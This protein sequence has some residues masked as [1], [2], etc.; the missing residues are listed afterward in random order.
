MIRTAIVGRRA[1]AGD[2]D[3]REIRRL[4][5][6]TGG[7]VVGEITQVRPEH[8]AT[9]FGPGKVA[10]IADRVDATG[11][12]AFVVDNPLT[13]TQTVNLEDAIDAA[14][15]DRH[16]VVLE[17]FAE[18]A[19]SGRAQLQVEL[20]RLRYELPRIRELDDPQ[21]MNIAQEKGHW[22]KDVRDR[23]DDLEGKLAEL[24]A[25]D[26]HRRG[27]RREAGFDLVAIAGYTN[28]GKTTLLRRLADDLSFE[29]DVHDDLE[30]TAAIEDRLFKT[31]E[32]TT[33]RATLGGR[34]VLLTD[35][36]GFLDDLP[37]WLV[38]S[39]RGT[40]AEAEAA[41]AVLLVAD[42]AQP[43]DELERKL[44]TARDAIP[45]D[46]PVVTALNKADLVAEDEI[47][48]R[49]TTAEALAPNPVVTSARTA[50]RMDELAARIVDALPSLETAELTLPLADEAM[51]V[52]SWL[53]DEAASVDVEYGPEAVSAEFEAKPPGVAK[54]RSRRG[55]R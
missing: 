34:D 42:L 21:P 44:A 28:A 37:H 49:L 20:A 2:P 9:Q 13:P 24:P 18:R 55:E 1:D 14:V 46:A 3:T 31:L 19:H 17:I 48:E 12:T 43:P 7:R 23:I 40:L 36:V 38:E 27:R 39:F 10:A 45:D 22:L 30:E 41:D 26:A 33:R 51:S 52:V 11:A 16:R 5:E 53:H 29:S 6:A 8:P 25:V 15:L 35:T 54:A 47:D 4:V 32:T 50:D